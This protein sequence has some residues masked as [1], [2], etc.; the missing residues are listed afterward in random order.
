MAEER[1]PVTET[2]AQRQPEKRYWLDERRNA[3]KVY[4]ALVAVCIALVLGDALFVKKVEFEFER[5]FG[6]F[7]WF[8]FVGSVFLVMTARALRKILM[9]PEDYYDR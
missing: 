9:K 5:M 6:F 3:M 8:G 1:E 7:G 4:W 2:P